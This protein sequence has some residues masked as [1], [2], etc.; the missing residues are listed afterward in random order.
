MPTM[1]G[2][3]SSS[4]ST[5]ASAYRFTPA[6]STVANANVSALNRCVGRLKR[7]RRYSGTLRTLEP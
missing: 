6:I 1:I 2:H 7:R 4:F 5:S 3:P